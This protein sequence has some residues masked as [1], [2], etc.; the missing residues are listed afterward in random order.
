MIISPVKRAVAVISIVLWGTTLFAMGTKGQAP[1]EKGTVAA[2]ASSAA[3]Q[4]KATVKDILQDPAKFSSSDVVLEGNF[5]GW[6][7]ACPSSSMLTRSDWILEDET[8]CIYVT[9][10]IPM[11]LAPQ[12]PNNER[13]VVNGRVMVNA[14]GKPCITVTQQP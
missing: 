5:K 12:Q 7:G 11:G 13:I 2:P 6:T 10:R 1:P 9:G 14:A 4:Q 3:A 8:G